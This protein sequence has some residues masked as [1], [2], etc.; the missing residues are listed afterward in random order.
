MGPLDMPNDDERLRNYKSWM[1]AIKTMTSALRLPFLF[2]AD[3][4]I[5][6]ASGQPASIVSVTPA[7]GQVNKMTASGWRVYYL[8]NTVKPVT[9]KVSYSVDLAP[10]SSFIIQC[11]DVI[12]AL[13]EARRHGDRDYT[14][15][16]LVHRFQQKDDAS[17]HYQI[18]P[19]KWH[20]RIPY[21]CRSSSSLARGST[22]YVRESW[23][24]TMVITACPSTHFQPICRQLQIKAKKTKRA[25]M[26][27]IRR[28]W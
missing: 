9:A 25:T 26:R 5:Y 7:A 27:R 6:R 18:L 4:A 20:Q 1:R 8:P 22:Q 3:K 23:S 24:R 28:V 13:N 17:T 16:Y 21:Y 2:E 11:Q 12:R 14:L 19:T 10:E 15:Q